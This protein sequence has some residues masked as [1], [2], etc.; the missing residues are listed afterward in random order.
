MVQP[1]L[2]RLIQTDDIPQELLSALDARDVAIWLRALPDEPAARAAI[3]SFLGLP[4]RLVL[5]EISERWLIDSLELQVD[6][7]DPKVRRRGFIQII[8]RDPSQLEL[9]QRCLPVYLLHGSTDASQSKFAD[10]VRQLTMLDA[11][12]RSD[13][14]YLLILSTAENPVPPQLDDL[15]QARFRPFLLFAT[16]APDAPA[17]LREW[18]DGR[19][20]Q[21]VPTLVRGSLART[22]TRILQYYENRYPEERVVIRVKSRDGHLPVDVTE[23]D[24]PEHPLLDSYDIIQER[25]LAY[26]TP[27][28]LTEQ[29]LA[30]FFRN[31]DASWRPYAAGLPWLRDNNV[32]NRFLQ[33]L[34]K[35][36]AVGSDENCITYVRAEPGGGGTTFVRA[37]AWQLAREG[38]PVL[39]GKQFPFVPD[40]LAVANFMN[41]VKHEQDRDHGGASPTGQPRSESPS[42]N[43]S[44]PMDPDRHEVPWIIVFDRVHWEHRET[45]LRRFRTEM[46]RQGR[47]VCLLVVSGPMRDAFDTAVFREVGQLDP[48]LDR[49]EARRLGQHLNRFLRVHGNDRTEWQWDQFYQQHTVKHLEGTVSFWIALSFWI[50]GQYDLSESIQ[51]WVYRSFRNHAKD[52]EVRDAVLEIAAMAAER[53]PIPEGLLPEAHGEWPT[54]VLLSDNRSVL[55]TIGLVRGSAF[56]Q[57]Y[58]AL[59]HDILGR[60]LFNAIF[61][62]DHSMKESLGFVDAQSP[63]HIRFQLLRRISQRAAL[64]ERAYREFGEEFAT[65]I[66]KIDPDH[67]HAAFAPL[68]RDVLTALDA[69][70]SSLRDGSRVFRHHTSVSRRRIAKFDENVYGVTR[71]DRIHLLERVID[72]LEYA[73]DAIPYVA[74]AEP[75]LNLYNSLAHAYHDLADVKETLGATSTEVAPLRRRATDATRRAYEESP[76]NSFVIETYVRDLLAT[77]NAAPESAVDYLIRALETLFAAMYSKGDVYRQQQLD[78]LTSSAVAAL[79]KCAPV[80]MLENDPSNPLEVL[81]RA[82][83]ILAQGMD[84]ERGM[85]FSAIPDESRVRAIEALAHPSGRGNL[86]VLRLSYALVA[87]TYPYEYRR[88]ITFLDQLDSTNPRTSP[89]LRLEYGVLLYQNDR[90]REGDRVFRDLRRLWRASEHYVEVPDRLHWLRDPQSRNRRTVSATI[91]SDSS[92]RPMASVREFQGI[93]V[94]FRPEEFGRRKVRPGSGFRCHVS[95]GHNGPFLRPVTTKDR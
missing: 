44:Q 21:L 90:S 88:Q 73:L 53:L 58:W 54:S 8:D 29:D 36:E 11:L 78:Q 18:I 40:A 50:H 31:P 66:F 32:Q 14:R 71:G 17:R 28:D 68:W 93:R 5:S 20:G 82:W 70:P 10:Q 27:D 30:A 79:F 64:G 38:Y 61:Y 91:V 56:G 9:P 35:I 1:T 69:M 52:H 16:D 59:A 41:R 92:V 22:T 49:E 84:Y 65:T 34:A 39:I 80:G 74:G 12:R 48:S 77:A 33:I 85:E 75:N 23:L 42:R 67:G 51:E 47:S 62:D 6:V 7:R 83:V 45:E 72:D 3:S 4:W 76:T 26:L 46:Q 55:A 95:F 60:L 2:P 89:Q 25:H 94:P 63:D 13:V 57:H 87:V 43:H 24:D 15:L 37:V 19:P 86:Q 81:T